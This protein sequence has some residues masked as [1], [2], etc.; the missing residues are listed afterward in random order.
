MQN[1]II[2]KLK[3]PRKLCIPSSVKLVIGVRGVQIA[4]LLESF[5]RQDKFVPYVMK[6]DN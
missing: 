3:M 2:E 5:F 6:S 1:L 4:I